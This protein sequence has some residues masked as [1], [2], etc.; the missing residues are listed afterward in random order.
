MK[1][2]C[3]NPQSSIQNLTELK[4]QIKNWGKELGFADIGI[5][6]TDLSHY[7]PF[8]WDWLKS[9]FHGEMEYMS[10]H[11]SKRTRPTELEP[12]TACIISV[13]I[14]YYDNSSIDPALVLH[15]PQK[16]YVSRYALGKDY[17][18]ILRKRLQKLSQRIAAETQHFAF[19]AFT[20]SAPVLEGAIAEKAGL[21]FIGKNSLNIHPKAGSWFFLGE[22]FCNL[23]LTP[24]QP[25]RKQG[26][27]PC[28]ACIQECPTQAIVANS[29]IDARRCISYLTIENKGSIPEE[30]RALMGNR[31]YGCDDC[32]LVCPWNKFTEATQETGFQN[33]KQLVNPD[34]LDLWKWDEEEFLKYF[35]GSPIRRIGYQQWQR[36]LAIAIG[37]LNGSKATLELAINQLK[38]RY[39]DVNDLV[40]EHIDWAIEQLQQKSLSNK[41]TTAD[42][43]NAKTQKFATTEQ[44][45]ELQTVKPWKANKY[46]IP[47][48]K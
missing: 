19:R 25:M 16:A 13:R 28:T 39:E 8:F 34:L 11:G 32:Q 10:R 21:G 31:I 15:N 43:K 24:D 4:T 37:N 14:N 12:N 44:I 2:A 47:R 26:C 27:G 18:K 38:K 22:L 6:D 35:E 20:D 42:S 36:N 29:V 30:F 40:K 33:R 48:R 23:P 46:F 1:K 45:K 41:L 17:H 3:L 5:A 9:D 7:E